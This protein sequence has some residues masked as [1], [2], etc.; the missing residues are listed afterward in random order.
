MKKMLGPNGLT[1]LHSNNPTSRSFCIGVWIKTGSRDEK[2][3]EGG[4]CHFLEH[5]LF[6]GTASR[7]A[8]ELSQEIER[9]GG[10][11]DAFTTKEHV[12]VYAQ[13]LESHAE[14]AFDVLGD[15]FSNPAFSSEQIEL[16]KQVVL[17]EIHDVLDAPDDLVHDLFAAAIFRYHPLGQ[18]ILGSPGSVSRFT[19]KQ[20]IDFSSRVFRASNMIVSVYGTIDGRRL[21]RLC[22]EHFSFPD[23]RVKPRIKKPGRFVPIRKVYR[24]KLHHQ[25]LCIGSRTCSYLEDRR[26][27]LMILTT[28]LGGG[29]SSRLFQRI[30]EELGLAYNIFTYS[31][32][33]RDT[34]LFGTYLAVSPDKARVAVRSVLAEFDAAR[35]GKITKSEV[36]DVKEHIIGKIL[37]GL[38]TS[39]AKMMRMARNDIFYGR[40]VNE[41][42]I[43][44]KI[45]DVKLDDLRRAASE[46]LAP[47]KTSIIGIGPTAA[48]VR[49]SL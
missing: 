38:E 49:S 46:V 32:Y 35:N 31:E 25:H 7:S 43:I 23:G 5:M 24:R 36:E 39:T 26:F 20:L 15:M 1:V 34:G 42:E 30:R 12:C 41:K 18:P 33:A 6:K 29:M 4:L 44:R 40:Q 28:L 27:P 8:L 13:V 21:Q 17:E 47:K 9:V 22:R 19:R 45:K 37:L 14:L 2:S 11:L 48:G 10:S 3:G 16:E